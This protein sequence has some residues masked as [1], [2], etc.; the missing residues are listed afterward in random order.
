VGEFPPIIHHHRE[1]SVNNAIWNIHCCLVS[2]TAPGHPPPLLF[3]Y[4]LHRHYHHYRYGPTLPSPWTTLFAQDPSSLQ[5]HHVA[6]STIS[7]H[8]PQQSNTTPSPLGR[9]LPSLWSWSSA[10]FTAKRSP[11]PPLPRRLS[12]CGLGWKEKMHENNR[13]KDGACI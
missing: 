7:W 9:H 3:P 13:Y 12:K 1:R 2:S 8:I 11:P 10:T 6:P 4:T 5:Y